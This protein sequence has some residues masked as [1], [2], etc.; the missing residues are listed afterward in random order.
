MF[1]H[2][3]DSNVISVNDIISII[4]HNLISSSVIME[5]MME[6]REY[7]GPEQDVKSVVI[8]DDLIYLSTLSV[9]TLEKRASYTSTINKLEDYSDDLNID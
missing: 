5:E 9:S 7:S 4:D 6:N 8:T 1:I 3:G 2:I